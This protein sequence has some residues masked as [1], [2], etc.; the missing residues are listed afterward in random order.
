ME[1]KAMELI[2]PQNNKYIEIYKPDVNMQKAYNPRELSGIANIGVMYLSW[3][4]DDQAMPYPSQ[5]MGDDWE[6]P[7][8]A[9]VNRLACIESAAEVQIP[10]YFK[11]LRGPGPMISI[12]R[13][14]SLLRAGVIYTTENSLIRRGAENFSVEEQ[15]EALKKEVAM[16]NDF[17]LEEVWC[18]ALF[19]PGSGGFDNELINLE[20]WRLKKHGV[21]FGD[22][23][24]Q[25]ILDK[26]DAND[27]N[28]SN[29]ENER[30][31]EEV[32]G[33]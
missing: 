3:N 10:L 18:Y 24:V 32:L 14:A 17:L 23:A 1:N 8:Y 4:D 27:W 33:R 26:F 9:E 5:G 19:E 7:E 29:L 11:F 20:D 30:E 15:K 21:F 6:F 16:Y 28:V 25:E 2:S 31:Q 12:E 22:N 13:E